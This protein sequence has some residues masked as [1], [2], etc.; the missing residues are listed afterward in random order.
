[1]YT[2]SSV[3]TFPEAPLTYGQPPRPATEEFGGIQE[4]LKGIAHM[5][6]GSEQQ[7]FRLVQPPLITAKSI[8]TTVPG[9]PTPIVSPSEISKQPISYSSLAT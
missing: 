5:C 8:G 2:T 4:C 1:M 3:A 9:V 7:A 6:H